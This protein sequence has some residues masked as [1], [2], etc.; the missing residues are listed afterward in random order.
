M[1]PVRFGL[2]TLFESNANVSFAK[3]YRKR[4]VCEK[5]SIETIELPCDEKEVVP[6]GDK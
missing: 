2:E 5:V 1:Q 3:K 6:G 4:L